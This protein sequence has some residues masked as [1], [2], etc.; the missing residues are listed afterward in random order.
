MIVDR[1]FLTPLCLD[2]EL[3]FLMGGDGRRM[4][5]LLLWWLILSSELEPVEEAAM[6]RLHLVIVIVIGLEV[7]SLLLVLR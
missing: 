5:A 1:R 6:L 7:R 2:S 4:R 3:L